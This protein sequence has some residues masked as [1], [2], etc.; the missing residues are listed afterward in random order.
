LIC[1]TAQEFIHAYVDGELDL[2][3][4]LEV[5]QHMQECQVCASAYRNQTALRSSFKDASLYYSAPRKLEKR[6]KS[7]LRREDFA[8]FLHRGN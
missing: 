3:R 4:T 5:E 2:A 1:Q 6:I 7:A 8:G